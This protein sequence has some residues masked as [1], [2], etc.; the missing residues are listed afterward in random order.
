MNIRTEEQKNTST[1]AHF[2]KLT[3]T[4]SAHRST[5]QWNKRTRKRRTTNNERR[6]TNNE[7]RITN[8]EQ[9]TKNNRTIEC[10]GEK[11]STSQWNN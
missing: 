8:K 9:R 11:L 10:F 5:S 7:Q 2:D 4:S 1:K 3:S 6:I